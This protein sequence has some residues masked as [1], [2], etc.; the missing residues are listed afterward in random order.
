M[1]KLLFSEYIYYVTISSL[2]NCLLIIMVSSGNLFNVAS[3]LILYAAMLVICTIQFLLANMLRPLSGVLQ[4]IS[5]YAL[6]WLIT[7]L[8][9]LLIFNTIF[10]AGYSI[11]K[12]AVVACISLPFQLSVI[13]FN[14]YYLQSKV[15]KEKDR[16]IAGF[17]SRQKA[18]EIE[19]L[20]QQIDPHFI[21]NSFNTLSFL[22]GE[23]SSRAKAFSD[24]LANVYRYIIFNGNKNLIGLSEELEFA[25]NYSYLQEIR[26]SN[27]VEVVFSNFSKVDNILII[28]VSIQLLIENA[29]KHNEFSETTPLIINVSLEDSHISVTNAKRLKITNTPVSSK[30]GLINLRERCNL[31]MHSE[32]EIIDS[33]SI[34]KVTV[35]VHRH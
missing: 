4:L 19:V 5:V 26:H 12:I 25:K 30:I 33:P 9:L 13:Y 35:P 16:Q 15:V 28:P 7:F 23:D 20:K 6:S 1:R 2:V 34:F 24:K 17:T 31:I 21:F 32:L 3:L 14:K 29:I 11:G 18:K 8:T 10:F 27:E 22:I